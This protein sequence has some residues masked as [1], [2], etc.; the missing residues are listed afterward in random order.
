MAEIIDNAA[1]K[2]A[3]NTGDL[4]GIALGVLERDIL[5]EENTDRLIDLLFDH[6]SLPRWMPSFVVKRVLDNMLPETLLRALHKLVDSDDSSPQP[7]P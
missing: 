7:A 6:L 1:I 2:F 4:R 5:T 3:A